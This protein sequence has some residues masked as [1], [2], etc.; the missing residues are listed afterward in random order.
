MNR[1]RNLIYLRATIYYRQY[2]IAMVFVLVPEDLT[3]DEVG[4]SSLAHVT[5]TLMHHPLWI[6]EKRNYHWITTHD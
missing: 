5:A 1:K 3:N 2:D 4:E 6:T